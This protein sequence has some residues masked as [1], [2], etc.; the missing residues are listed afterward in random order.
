MS[1]FWSELVE[2]YRA[3]LEAVPGEMGCKTRN[4]LYGYRAQPGCRVLRNVTIRFP[5]KLTLGRNVG[6]SPNTQFNAAGGIDIGDDTLIG[7]GCM[8]W[9]VNHRF[10]DPNVPIRCQGY[11]PGK[12]VIGG[13]CWIAGHCVI[14]PGVELG[15]GSVVAAGSV[16]TR[17]FG[18]GAV[19]A[20]VP[21]R[22]VRS[23]MESPIQTA[24]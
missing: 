8:V 18:A 13:N 19:L 16:V 6:I 20:G 9:S 3:L 7:P 23:R 21:A 17:S 11:V 5:E 2:W 24:S 4:V 10:D 14:L 15:T 12:V 1:S 22:L